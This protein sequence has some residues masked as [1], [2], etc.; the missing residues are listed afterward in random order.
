MLDLQ[1]NG[2][3]IAIKIPVNVG[4]WMW[5]RGRVFAQQCEA[6]GSALSTEK[7]KQAY[8]PDLV[9]VQVSVTYF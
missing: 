3:C 4:L 6:L 9:Q 2:D 7:T 5:F 1:D 8:K